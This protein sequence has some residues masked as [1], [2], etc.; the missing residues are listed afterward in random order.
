MNIPGTLLI[1][2]FICTPAASFAFQSVDRP[3]ASA[4]PSIIFVQDDYEI[5]LKSLPPNASFQACLKYT[6][7]ACAQKYGSPDDNMCAIQYSNFVCLE[8]LQACQA[9]GRTDCEDTQ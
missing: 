1:A 5:D 2:S 3:E 4:R 8:R 6:S 7:D 9:A